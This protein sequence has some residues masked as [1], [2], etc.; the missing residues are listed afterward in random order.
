MPNGY[1]AD[2]Y[3]GKDITL[4]EYLMKVGRGMSMAIMQRDEALDAP[5]KLR[6]PSKY[7]LERLGEALEAKHKLLTMTQ[8]DRNSAAAQ[9]WESQKLAHQQAVRNRDGMRKRYQAMIDQVEAWEP[10]E[11]VAYVKEHALRYLR[12]SMDFDC[13]SSGRVYPE[14]PGD[15]WNGYE[16][17]DKELSRLN[18]DIE[19]HREAWDEEVERVNDFNEH[20]L[21]FHESLPSE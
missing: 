11:K 3:E 17:F 21:A 15:T 6:E 18:K 8:A 2:I 5:V 4:R 1:T 14:D 16:W 20:I 19:Y 7:S 10:V 9:E 12:E 13:P